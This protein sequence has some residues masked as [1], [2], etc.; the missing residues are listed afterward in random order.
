MSAKLTVVLT[1]AE[2]NAFLFA[3]G[4]I[5]DASGDREILDFYCGRAQTRDAA[6]RARDKIR[7]AFHKKP[8]L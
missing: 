5:L 8:K 2:A 7:D 6:F 4:N 3:A 1:E